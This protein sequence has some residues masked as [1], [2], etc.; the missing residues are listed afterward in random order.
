[1]QELHI[2][3]CADACWRIVQGE[4]AGYHRFTEVVLEF[5]WK[6]YVIIKQFGRFPHRNAVLGRQ[7]TAEE[8]KYLED[9]GET[10]GG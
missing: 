5:A 4:W 8:T 10:F 9:G 2:A 6:H 7:P 3:K 1:M